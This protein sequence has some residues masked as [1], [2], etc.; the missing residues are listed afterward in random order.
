MNKSEP[1]E[2]VL[3][4]NDM[5]YYDTDTVMPFL[6][7]AYAKMQ[8]YSTVIKE[9]RLDYRLFMPAFQ[10]KEALASAAIE[11]T[12][13]TIEDV[14]ESRI[15]EKSDS[16]KLQEIANCYD[17][18]VFGFSYLQ[19]NHIDLKFFNELNRKLLEGQV[20]KDSEKVGVLR[21]SQNCVKNKKT[22]QITYC[23][24][25]PELMDSYM[26]NLLD[27]I[28]TPDADYNELVRIAII[29]AQFETIHPYNDGNGRVGRILVPLYLY[30]KRVIPNPYFFIS[31]VLESN[32][33]KY[34]NQ[35]TKLRETGNWDEWIIF[36]LDS[37]EKQ[38]DKYIQRIHD[39]NQLYDKDLN[40]MTELIGK[41]KG[42]QLLE[43]FFRSP[44]LNA[45]AVMKKMNSTRNTALKYLQ[46]MEKSRILYSNGK[47][48]YVIYFYDELL[49][50]L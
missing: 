44:V 17:S 3:L 31:D 42:K 10:T 14:Y 25:K 18:I 46:I 40:R 50:L 43:L 37:I 47:D 9:S 39:I 41:E 28:E 7:K 48:R 29:H 36:F 35:L 38:C 22:G 19:D 26:S 49:S 11:G 5:K 4:S 6:L 2:A 27:Y 1:F 33:T 30:Y 13:A 24:P 12:Q 15:D 21:T 20:H 45:N 8:V 34:Y 16:R 32:R 23:P